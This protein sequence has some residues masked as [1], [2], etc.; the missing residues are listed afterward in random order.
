MAFGS[1]LGGEKYQNCGE[2]RDSSVYN[3]F[4]FLTSLSHSISYPSATARSCQ[5]E[6]PDIVSPIERI[7]QL[8]RHSPRL[9]PIYPLH[10]NP[11]PLP[12]FNKHL[13]KYAFPPVL[14]NVFQLCFALY[15]LFLVHIIRI[16]SC[17]PV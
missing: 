16:G 13:C 3:L 10:H 6:T 17:T 11:P 14:S 9:L 7:K 15:L 1:P 5:K 12:H 8:E 4:T 2:Y